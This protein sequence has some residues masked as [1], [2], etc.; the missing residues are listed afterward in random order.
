M[1]KTKNIYLNGLINLAQTRLGTK[2][3]YKTDEFFAPASRILNPTPPVFKNLPQISILSDTG[4]G[5][6]AIACLGFM[7]VESQEKDDSGSIIATTADG[8][9]ITVNASDIKTSVNCFLQ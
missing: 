7:I 3:V 4:V 1:T 6:V 9:T 2:I 8:Q 5:A